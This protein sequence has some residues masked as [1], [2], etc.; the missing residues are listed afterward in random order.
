MYLATTAY[1]VA[2]LLGRISCRCFNNLGT[3]LLLHL[4]VVDGNN[5]CQRFVFVFP[6]GNSLLTLNPNSPIQCHQYLAG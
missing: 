5:A 2:L 1:L 3:W 4:N 6:K